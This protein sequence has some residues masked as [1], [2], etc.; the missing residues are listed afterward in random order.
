[1]KRRLLSLLAIAIT[2]CN[3]TMA[4][5]PQKMNY[6][7]IVRDA[8]G[9]PLPGGT[10]VSVRFQIHDGSAGGAVVFQ[11][12]NTAVTNQ[13][14]LITQ[15]IG[16]TGNLASVNWGA[17]PKYLQVEIDVTGGSNYVDMGTSQLI[18][19]PYALY[20][21]NSAGGATGPTGPVGSQGPQGLPG[22]TGPQGPAGTAGPQGAAGPAGATGPAGTAGATGTQGAVGAAGPAGAT[23]AQGAAGATGPQGAAGP[24]GPTGANGAVGATGPAGATGADGA[25][26]ATGAAGAVGATGADGAVGATGADGVQGA[27]GADGAVGATGAD[28][29]AGPAGPTGA[30]GAA[31]PAGATGAT[32]ADGPQGPAGPTGADGAAGPTGADGAPGA[33]GAD[34]AD[35]AVGATGATGDVGPTGADGA[36]GATGATGDAG[37]TGATGPVGCTNINIVL[38][39]NGV[40]ATCSQIFDDGTNVGVGTV[41][42]VMPFEVR[43]AA[44]SNILTSGGLAS[45][46]LVDRD[47]VGGQGGIWWG[48]KYHNGGVGGGT[49]VW[50]LG[51]LNGGGDG[52]YL[53]NAG[54]GDFGVAID[55]VRD[56]VGIGTAGAVY[57][58]K[59]TVFSDSA[60]ISEA[61]FGGYNG[62]VNYVSGVYGYNFSIDSSANNY[63]V[64]GSYNSNSVWGVGVIGAGFGYNPLPDSTIDVGV[65]GSAGLSFG[66]KGVWANTSTGTALYADAT[67]GGY[68]AQLFGYLQLADGSEA[69]GKVLASDAAGNASWETLSNL[70]AIYSGGTGISIGAGNVINSNWTNDGSGNIYNNNAGNVG[71]GTVTPGNQLEVVTTQASVN[72]ILGRN[73]GTTDGIGWYP[74]ANFAGVSGVADSAN[75]QFQAGVFGWDL[76]FGNNSGGVVGAWSGN[77][78]AALGYQD[79][80]GN[81]FSLYSNSKSY[82]NGSVQIVDGTE[83]TGKVLTSDVAGNATWQD[84]SQNPQESF[85][86]IGSLSA[87][88]VPDNVET[89]VPYDYSLHIDNAIVAPGQFTATADGV[90]HIDA[91]VAYSAFSANGRISVRVYVN[92]A[93]ASENISYVLAM[94]LGCY[95]KFSGIV[96]L[97]AGDVVTIRTLQRSGATQTIPVNTFGA[98]NFEAFKLY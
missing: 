13:F 8:L 51:T 37:P 44:F 86:L 64:L 91:S 21:A 48:T 62:H 73:T 61:I 50:F 25:I 7:A 63:G 30:D 29:A 6:Q 96:K 28:G 16:G 1:M 69:A 82:F 10:N 66:S 3:V 98:H 45:H 39:S 80:T 58:E 46:F 87:V 4:Q 85:R 36:V 15:I 70:G 83:G 97:V 9:N 12:S 2:F 89:N 84:V 75:T 35:G 42:P 24:Q 77:D 94:G 74:G 5:S 95:A 27:T 57:D 59:L 54:T 65:Y 19:V 81:I 17:G 38:K 18:S 22:S 34:G 49:D 79:A 78:W 52:L 60:S 93:F 53:Y 76:G 55:N 43:N 47:A 26:G 72:A 92:G 56:N 40:T 68:A 14:G 41:L 71:I 23:G 20:A 90:Y 33:T 11:E 31:G 67:A 32:G 88:S